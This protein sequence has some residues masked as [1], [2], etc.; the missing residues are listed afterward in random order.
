M[1]S[2][3]PEEPLA[4]SSV[5]GFGFFPAHLEMELHDGRYRVVRKLGRGQLSS[6]WLVYDSR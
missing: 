5:E 4:L 2:L 6:T 1:S 3:F